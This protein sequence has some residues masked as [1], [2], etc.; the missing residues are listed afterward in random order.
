MSVLQRYMKVILMPVP[1]DMQI[2]VHP[3]TAMHDHQGEDEA[4]RCIQ[5]V[6]DAMIITAN[7]LFRS[8][9]PP[10]SHAPP[11]RLTG[12]TN[13]SHTNQGSFSR[14]LLDPKIITLEGAIY[15]VTGKMLWK[16]RVKSGRFVARRRPSRV[17]RGAGGGRGRGS[18]G[19]GRRSSG[20]GKIAQRRE[21]KEMEEEENGEVEDGSEEWEIEGGEGV[22]SSGD[23]QPR[24]R[25]SSVAGRG[26]RVGGD[27]GRKRKRK[28]DRERSRRQEL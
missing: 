23:G 26:S 10:S 20:R 8:P 7:A 11:C 5:R 12:M 14:K 1:I 4:L 3:S 16:R 2:P 9:R 25:A 6:K 27:G 15:D 21:E 19:A 13:T 22:Q 28:G 18:L 17:S 24:R